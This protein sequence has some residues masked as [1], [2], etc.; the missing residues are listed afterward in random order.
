MESLTETSPSMEE[1]TWH[2]SESIKT[3]EEL[4]NNIIS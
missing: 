2:H 4:E 1:L 3:R